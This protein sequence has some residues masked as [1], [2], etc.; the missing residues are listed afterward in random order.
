MAVECGQEGDPGSLNQAKQIIGSFICSDV[1]GP[2]NQRCSTQHSR[3]VERSSS[4]PSRRVLTGRDGVKVRNGFRY[5]RELKAFDLVQHNE[6]L[7]F[8]DEVLVHFG[9]HSRWSRPHVNS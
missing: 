5:A 7:A 9:V 2:I 3:F 8:D 4:N 6:L 1:F